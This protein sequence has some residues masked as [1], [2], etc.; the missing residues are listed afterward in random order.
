MQTKEERGEDVTIPD[1]IQQ[2]CLLSSYIVDKVPLSHES[3]RA[4]ESGT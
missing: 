4:D 1:T 3:L 2:T